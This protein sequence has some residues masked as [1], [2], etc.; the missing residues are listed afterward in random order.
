MWLKPEF[1]TS[2]APPYPASL[3]LKCRNK[4]LLLSLLK[5]QRPGGWHA[6]QPAASVHRL[7]NIG[8]GKHF[9]PRRLPLAFDEWNWHQSLSSLCSLVETHQSGSP[10]TLAVVH[11]YSGEDTRA[12]FV[13][14]LSSPERHVYVTGQIKLDGTFCQISSCIHL[15]IHFHLYFHCETWISKWICC[16]LFSLCSDLEQMTR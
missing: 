4:F 6:A 10:S 15:G 14:S 7:L 3:C 16:F 2:M 8:W 5:I 12:N 1:L 13:C 9:H 11:C